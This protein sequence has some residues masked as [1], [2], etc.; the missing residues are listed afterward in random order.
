MIT[1]SERGARCGQRTI[2]SGGIAS[3]SAENPSEDITVI[4]SKSG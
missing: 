2:R 4:G 1:L 3:P